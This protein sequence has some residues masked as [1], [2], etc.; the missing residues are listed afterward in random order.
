VGYFA[1][2]DGECKEGWVVIEHGG[3]IVKRL[4]ADIAMLQGPFVIR[5]EED[6]TD[7]P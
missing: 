5:L 1:W 3:E 7:Q 2:I 4:E 6:C